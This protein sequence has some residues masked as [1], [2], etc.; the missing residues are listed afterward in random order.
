MRDLVP[1]M[2]RLP[3]ELHAQLKA[4]AARNE[5]SLNA[6]LIWRLRRSLESYRQ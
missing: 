4:A 6:E 5:R 3:A 2:L 1:L